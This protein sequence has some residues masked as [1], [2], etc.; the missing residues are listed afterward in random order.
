[1]RANCTY[2]NTQCLG[3]SVFAWDGFPRYLVRNV[4]AAT[5]SA[6][7]SFVFLVG[8][9]LVVELDSVVVQWRAVE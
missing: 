9:S 3:Q 8:G 5:S 6:V 1:M 4:S 7:D 2:L